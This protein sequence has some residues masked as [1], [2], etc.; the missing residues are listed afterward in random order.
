MIFALLV[1]I[2]LAILYPAFV[3]EVFVAAFFAIMLTIGSVSNLGVIWVLG[4]Y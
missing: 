2:L 4:R 3:R 1:L